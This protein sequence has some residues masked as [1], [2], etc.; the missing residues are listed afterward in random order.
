MHFKL[1]MGSSKADV[2]NENSLIENSFKRNL[3]NA[4]TIGG[5]VSRL[6]WAGLPLCSIQLKVSNFFLVVL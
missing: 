1:E 2:E 3:Q 4:S 5:Q 6:L